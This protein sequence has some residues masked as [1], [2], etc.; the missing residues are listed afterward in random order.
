MNVS[1]FIFCCLDEEQPTILTLV[2]VLVLISLLLKV[3]NRLRY[4]FVFVY[5]IFH[6]D[7]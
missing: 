4:C 2:E 1:I 6:R 3:F 5:C 7:H